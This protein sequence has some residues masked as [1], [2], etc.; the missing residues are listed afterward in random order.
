MPHH[1]SGNACSYIMQLCFLYFLLVGGRYVTSG[2]KFGR[3]GRQTV[4][5]GIDT[6]LYRQFKKKKKTI[7][8][9]FTMVQ[10]KIITFPEKKY[11]CEF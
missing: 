1:T 6:F 5:G 7:H 11:G 9:A 4:K 3:G 2:C 8:R 10:N